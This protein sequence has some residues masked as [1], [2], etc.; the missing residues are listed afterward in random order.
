MG[1][2]QSY[3]G[4]MTQKGKGCDVVLGEPRAL[5]G[6]G[7]GSLTQSMDRKKKLAAGLGILRNE[8]RNNTLCTSSDRV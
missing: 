2:L 3:W 6:K 8:H 7:V 1:S 5:A 4:G